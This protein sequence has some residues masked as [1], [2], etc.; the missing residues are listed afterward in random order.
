MAEWTPGD[1][2][3]FLTALVAA[4]ASIG[5]TITTILLQIRGNAKTEQAKAISTDSNQK[6]T[7]VV[8]Q[9]RNIAD[10]VPGASTG[11]TDTVSQRG[12]AGEQPHQRATD[13]QP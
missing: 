3:I 8:A 1:W 5:G 13:P 7:A 6:V 2:G 11:P 4:V 12:P 10:A 9:V